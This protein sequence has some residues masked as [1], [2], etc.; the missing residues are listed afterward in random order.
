MRKWHGIYLKQAKNLEK[1]LEMRCDF[2]GGGWQVEFK[3]LMA[4]T[5]DP[6]QL[7]KMGFMTIHQIPVATEIEREK[8]AIVGKTAMTFMSNLLGS[9][10]YH[11]NK[12]Y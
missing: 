10:P 2:A 6:Y 8:D 11:K 4:I 1:C 5:S 7:Q 9:R 12:H 3:E